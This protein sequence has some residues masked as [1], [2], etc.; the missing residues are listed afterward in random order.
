ME[1]RRGAGVG[2]SNT[3]ALCGV[4][5]HAHMTLRATQ[6]TCRPGTLYTRSSTG[7][8]MAVYKKVHTAM[9]CMYMAVC[10][11]VCTIPDTKAFGFSR[12]R[13]PGLWLQAVSATHKCHRPYRQSYAGMYVEGHLH[14][15]RLRDG[16]S[17]RAVPPWVALQAME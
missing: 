3:N 1:I 13:N 14:A 8:S 6:S 10:A 5:H 9:Y 2:E 16:P 17:W 12:L 15:S 11:F 4:P 7:Q